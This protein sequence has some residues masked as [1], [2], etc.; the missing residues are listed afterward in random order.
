MDLVL[1]LERF[2]NWGMIVLAV[3]KQHWAKQPVCIKLAIVEG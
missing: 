2:L 1:T 3:P